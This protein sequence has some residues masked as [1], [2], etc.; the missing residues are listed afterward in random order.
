MEFVYTI[1]AYTNE[2][3]MLI[4]RHIGD[5]GGDRGVMADQFC[6]ELM[7]LDG[8]GK[9]SIQIW[10]NSIGG[11]VMDGMQIY[12]AINKCKTPISTYNLGI[13]ASSAA[14]IFQAGSKRI[15]SDY[16]L[17]MIHNPFNMDGSEDET[18]NKIKDSV[19]TMLSNKCG[20]ER[21]VIGSMMDDETWFDA[22]ECLDSG[23]CDEIESYDSSLNLSGISDI[24]NKWAAAQTVLN[25]AIQKQKFTKMNKVLNLLQLQEGANE[26][27]V[28]NAVQAIKNEAEELK[29]QLEEISAQV[30]TLNAEK[31]ELEA[32]VQEAEQKEAEAQEAALNAEATDVVNTFKAR[33]GEANVDK[34]V[35]LYKQNPEATK[36]L[37]EGLPLNVAAPKIEDAQPAQAYNMAAIMA[38]KA[39]NNK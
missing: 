38:A 14:F 12:G 39:N 16:A 21:E 18:L 27:V 10:I 7:Y 32:K 11:V 1:D 8:L 33:I 29:A 17:M 35:N 19:I 13:A 34:W 15:M 24:N 31:V 6:R 2:P 30:E 4:D 28:L 20:K 23:F 5:M 26:D 22:W 9:S 37:L 25:A 36:E 3:I